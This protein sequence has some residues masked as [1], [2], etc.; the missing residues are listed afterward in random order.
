MS[1][2]E[3]KYYDKYG[4]LHNDVFKRNVQRMTIMLCLI[5]FS[6]YLLH[7]QMKYLEG[8]IFTNSNYCAVSSAI[9][10]IFGSLIYSFLGG[11]KP[12]YILGFIVSIVGCL[13]I[14][15]RINDLHDSSLRI[16]HLEQLDFY[17]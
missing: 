3:K 10:I 4:Y 5:A 16:I 8:S 11:I 2:E 12:T 13:A 14:L 7:M 15:H 17:K 9:A 1:E 6:G